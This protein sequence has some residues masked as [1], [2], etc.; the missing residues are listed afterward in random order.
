MPIWRDILQVENEDSPQL[1]CFRLM[2]ATAF[3]PHREVV[4]F[5]DGLIGQCAMD[6]RQRLVSEIPQDAS[7]IN[8]RCCVSYEESRGASGAV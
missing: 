6:R 5:G 3:D 8:S 7:P 4:Q 1:R 2:P